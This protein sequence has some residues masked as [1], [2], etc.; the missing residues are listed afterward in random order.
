MCPLDYQVSEPNTDDLHGFKT[1]LYSQY[2]VVEIL[3]I[4]DSQCTQW[5]IKQNRLRLGIWFSF[6][7][8]KLNER[9]NASSKYDAIWLEGSV[10]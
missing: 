10:V 5:E 9:L 4:L 7:Y 1:I 8:Q 2:E 6:S 3:Y